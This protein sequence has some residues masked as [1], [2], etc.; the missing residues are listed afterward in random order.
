MVLILM[1][2][3]FILGGVFIISYASYKYIRTRPESTKWVRQILLLLLGAYLFGL[4]FIVVF[5]LYQYCQS[6]QQNGFRGKINVSLLLAALIVIVL[7]KLDQD[8]EPSSIT[9]TFFSI[10]CK[11]IEQSAGF[12]HFFTVNEKETI[13]LGIKAIDPATKNTWPILEYSADDIMYGPV[14]DTIEKRYGDKIYMSIML[15]SMLFCF[16]ELMHKA[17]HQAIFYYDLDN[18]NRIPRTLVMDVREGLESGLHNLNSVTSASPEYLNAY[19]N[20]MAS[21]MANRAASVLKPTLC[22][23]YIRQIEMKLSIILILFTLIYSIVLAVMGKVDILVVLFVS[24]SF[25]L[26]TIV[27][28][29]TLD[30]SRYSHS[31]FPI[32][33]IINFLALERIVSALDSIIRKA[34]AN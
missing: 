29:H 24:H 32:F 17:I 27:V 3:K 30:I 9:K 33:T 31:L 20:N 22:Q 1:L 4:I 16:P 26:L 8:R 23:H 5:L 15:K 21:Y 14:S 12:E 6:Q 25:V 19:R 34:L 7:A 2:P 18:S 28:F 13:K 10:N 11:I